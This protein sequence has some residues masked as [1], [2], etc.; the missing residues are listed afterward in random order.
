MADENEPVTEETAEQ[1]EVEA[2]AAAEVLDLQ[3]ISVNATEALDGRIPGSCSS[4]VGSF[5]M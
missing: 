4:C 2:H 5:C 1:P 3:G